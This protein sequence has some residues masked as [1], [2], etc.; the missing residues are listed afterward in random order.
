MKKSGLLTVLVVSAFVIATSSITF[1]QDKKPKPLHAPHAL[2]GVEPEMLSPD[3]WISLLPDADE[4]VMTPVDIEQFNNRERTE[5]VVFR[6]Q[7]GKPDPLLRNYAAKLKIGLF[8]HPIK[9]LDLPDTI[10]GDSLR[11]WLQSSIDYLKSRDFYD[12]R[13]ATYNED[14]KQE[15]IDK[16]TIEKVRQAVSRGHGPHPPPYF[17]G[18]LQRNKMGNGYVPDHRC[19]YH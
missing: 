7:F 12:S 13:N 3:Y 4:I 18:R 14:M 2:P 1:S 17:G 5:K 10:P 16:V 8:M 19:L 9:P 11:V 6:D 15:L